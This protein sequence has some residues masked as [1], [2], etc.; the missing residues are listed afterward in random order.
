MDLCFHHSE[1]ELWK[2]IIDEVF[3]NK[4]K[5]NADDLFSPV[6]LKKQGISIESI[7][8]SF[9]DNT[10]PYLSP[11]EVGPNRNAHDK[12]YSQT[13]RKFIINHDSLH[14]GD[15]IRYL[16]PSN[17]FSLFQQ[18][19]E[20]IVNAEI[21]KENLDV[22]QLGFYLL[23]HEHPS[24]WEHYTHANES[25]LVDMLKYG[26]DATIDLLFSNFLYTDADTYVV[27]Y[28]DS[29]EGIVNLV[30]KYNTEKD[31]VFSATCNNL[32]HTNR[33]VQNLSDLKLFLNAF[34]TKF[35]K[36]AKQICCNLDQI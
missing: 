10:G 23:T 24:V 7:N 13:N 12:K 9:F 15:T 17:V 1:K 29:L 8:F 26:I 20:C 11:V 18:F 4:N 16:K 33:S 30:K 36:A 21:G 6:F 27:L 28:K 31:S 34:K 35:K 14:N 19:Y 5:G 32:K 3:S 22:L 2:A 25:N